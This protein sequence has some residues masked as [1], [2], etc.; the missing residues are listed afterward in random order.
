MTRNSL[1]ALLVLASL[2]PPAFAQEPPAA[3]SQAAADDI[4]KIRKEALENSKVMETLS[5]LV[6]VIGPRLTNSPGMKRANEWT[7]TT[8][9]G[10][11]L[12]NAQLEP[13]GP[14]G[15]GWELKKFSLQ[16]VEPQCIPVIAFPKAWSPGVEGGTITAPLVYLDAETPEDL[17]KYKGKLKGALVLNGPIRPIEARFE[18]LASRRTEENLLG[19]ANALPPGERGRPAAGGPRGNSPFESRTEAEVAR[20]RQQAAVSRAREALLASE[21]PAAVLTAS[22]RG[23][24]GTLFVQSASLPAA[25]Q[26]GQGGGGPGAASRPRVWS[27]DAPK[28]T[29]Q[30]VL[31]SEHF[32]RLA[33]MARQGEELKAE[34]VLDVKF[35]DDD[36]MGYNTVA[37]IPG[38]DPELK[39]QVVM[40][41]GHLDS[42]HSA[43][44]ATDNAAGCA[45]GMEAV[46]ILKAL[47]LKPRRTIRIALWSGEEQGLI[48]SREYVAKHFGKRGEGNQLELTPEHEKFSAYYNLD[49]G[50]GKIRGIYLQGNEAARPYFRRW[51]APFADLGAS[52]VSASNTGGTDHQSF[53][54]VG[55]P[56][57][58]FIQD[59]IE[60]DTRTHHSNMDEYDRAQADDLKQAAA[61]MAAFVYQTAQMDELL[62]RKPLPNPS[63]SGGRGPSSSAAGN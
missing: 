38:T 35:H 54:G 63:S 58:Q 15:R 24:G 5:Y 37:E 6:D 47:D 50:T 61:I 33:R 34:L 57:F 8:L 11:G 2:T 9:E 42:W 7:K 21:E 16:V 41:G 19:L 20:M 12:E 44:C 59:E 62:P 1:A 25:G 13:F 23:D 51:L 17:E 14:F 22:S 60:Y 36:L 52:T 46:R 53:D 45:V 31:A 18:P 27:P 26:P 3:P 29:P 39:D 43:G 40:L 28:V 10:Y 32:N 4:A 48:G 30:I 56:G 49:N 55:L